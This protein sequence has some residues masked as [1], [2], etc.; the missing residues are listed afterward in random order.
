M[1][2]SENKMRSQQRR[3]YTVYEVN[4]GESLVNKPE[5]HPERP[6]TDEI[7]IMSIFLKL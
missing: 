1:N 4:P 7:S 5:D 6:K 3:T 2:N